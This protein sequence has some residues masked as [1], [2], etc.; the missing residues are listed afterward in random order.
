MKGVVMLR[1]IENVG[2][3]INRRSTMVLEGFVMAVL[4]FSAIPLVWPKAAVN[5]FAGEIQDTNCAA[6]AE[7]VEKECALTCT[8]GSA[9]AS[10][11]T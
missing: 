5:T 3:K 1:Q 10:R 2:L 6:T 8:A 7:H 9:Y 4:V 11:P